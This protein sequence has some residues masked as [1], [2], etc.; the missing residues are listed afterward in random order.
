MGSAAVARLHADPAFRVEIEAAKNELA[1]VRAKG[2][3]PTRDCRAEAD[4]LAIHLQ[5]FDGGAKILQ[6]RQGDYPVNQIE[7]L[8]KK[9]CKQAVGFIDASEDYSRENTSFY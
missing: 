8:P 9:Q 5:P 2:L 3:K 4:A 6:S 7:V 1:A